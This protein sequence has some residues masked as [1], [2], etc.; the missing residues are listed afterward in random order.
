LEWRVAVELSQDKVGIEEL[1]N[2]FDAHSDNQRRFKFP[3]WEYIGIDKDKAAVG[4]MVAKKYLFKL[5]FGA[6]AYSYVEDVELNF[7]S[8]SEKFWQGVIDETYNKYKGLA[9]WHKDI[10]QD[11]TREG[12]IRS[13]TGREWKFAPAAGYRGDLRW[14]VT[15]IKN[16]PVQGTGADLVQLARISSWRRLEKHRKEGK[17]LFINTVHDDIQQDAIN[18]PGLLYKVC[19]EMEQ[20]FADIPKNV[21]K[22]YGYKMKVP[23][24]G[25]V[26][27]GWNLAEMTEFH[28]EKGKDQ[29]VL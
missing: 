1:L 17:L 2:K 14:P 3:G 6:T 7:V 20:V 12:Y 10:V 29:F 24:A 4:R 28:K 18:D 16:Y 23:L 9:K 5:I 26:S 25:E 15:K 8:K 13:F 21:E 22:I 19:I 11:V 27:F